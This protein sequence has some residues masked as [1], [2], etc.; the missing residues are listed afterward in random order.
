MHD[1]PRIERV[2]YLIG[3]LLLGSGLLH[4]AILAITGGS[5]VGPLS[6]RKPATFGVSFGLTLITMTWVSSYLRIGQRARTALLTVFIAASVVETL[7]ISIQ[8]W[9]GVPSHFNVETIGDA[10]VAQV[11]AAGGMALVIIVVVLTLASFRPQP[12]TPAGMRLAI[13][14]GFVILVGA[15]ATGGLMIAKGMRLVFAGNPQAA[16]LTGG[17]LKPAHAVAMHAI[18]VL[19]LLAWMLSRTPL[20]E[21]RQV[22]VVS[23]AA[24]GYALAAVVVTAV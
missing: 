21:R 13:R 16:Y 23:L 1:R 15:M 8:T 7:L 24:A 10:I 12:A 3:A 5:W 6:L 22:W 17:S 9:R 11:L 19:P 4:V 20:S 18:L 14:A 2:G